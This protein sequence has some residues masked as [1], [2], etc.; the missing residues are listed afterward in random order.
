M[1]IKKLSG[2]KQSLDAYK[3]TLDKDGE[4]N[5]LRNCQDIFHKTVGHPDAFA[6][7]AYLYRRFGAPTYGN[8]ANPKILF[9]YDFI[10]D[11]ILITI[12]GNTGESVYFKAYI[13]GK[14]TDSYLKGFSEFRDSL[15][16]RLHAKDL[17]YVAGGDLPEM[18][19]PANLVNKNAALWMK[20]STGILSEDEHR[21]ISSLRSKSASGENLSPSEWETVFALTLKANRTI[22]EKLIEPEITDDERDRYYPMFSP[23]AFPDVA[24]VAESFCKE[25]LNPMP[26][27]DQNLNIN[28][29]C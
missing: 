15:I 26:V 10:V 17:P 7:L 13:P 19:V 20:A 29:I 14:S 2:V 21:T 11:G 3:A 6:V 16:A 25:L 5:E 28:G 1:K 27:R 4:I 9:E 23:K 18:C 24:A 8:E 12:H 22:S